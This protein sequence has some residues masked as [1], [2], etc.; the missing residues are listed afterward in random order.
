MSNIYEKI[1]IV[2]Y[3]IIVF[4]TIKRHEVFS[5][6][7]LFYLT[8]GFFQGNRLILNQL[9]LIQDQFGSHDY[10]FE[11]ILL[12]IS[13]ISFKLA[14]EMGIKLIPSKGSEFRLTPHKKLA[15]LGSIII[16]IT[17]P[18]C[19]FLVIRTLLSPVLGRYG[20]DHVG[21]SIYE[22]SALYGAVIGIQFINSSAFPITKKTFRLFSLVFIPRLILGFFTMR[23]LFAFFIIAQINLWYI[24]GFLK[25]NFLR[26]FFL[27]S[28]FLLPIVAGLTN[29]I[30]FY[31]VIDLSI[32]SI[33]DQINPFSLFYLASE[34]IIIT[35]LALDNLQNM[36][37]IIY[38]LST[39][40]SIY[41]PFLA[42]PDY[43]LESSEGILL[44]R[45]DRSLTIVL[46]RDRGIEYAGTGGNYIADLF[47]DGGFWAVA[48]G[49]CFIGFFTALFVVKMKESRLF[50]FLGLYF[51]QKLLYSPRGTFTEIFD[52]LPIYAAIFFVG[53]FLSTYLIKSRFKKSE[54]ISPI[55]D[56]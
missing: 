53:K 26:I 40:I 18:F 50:L 21:P 27:L 2:L 30:R 29:I 52:M 12:I 28:L 5:L 48:F 44:N 19:F 47:L 43:Y 31:K 20:V 13:I 1:F 42:T 39:I 17:L 38:S 37:N 10:S 51:S 46:F 36:P 24:A 35:Q 32:T 41:L 33:F 4:D 9:P 49:S 6:P 14:Y 8:L 56:L 7:S 15:G 34:P 11:A 22:K 3:F 45:L 54:S 16:K 55:P 23:S 25:R